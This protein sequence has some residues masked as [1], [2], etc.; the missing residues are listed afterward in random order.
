MI[1]YILWDID[2]TLLDFDYAEF[3]SL[4]ECFEKFNVG[5]LT[6]ERFAIYREINRKYWKVLER[7]EMD[8][9]EMLENRFIEFFTL[10]NIDTSIAFE[11]NEEYQKC[12]GKY[13]KFIKNAEETVK[14]FK[15][16]YKQ[17]AV[18]NGTLVAQ[19]K[20]LKKSGLYTLLD[21]SFISE[22]IGFDKPN[23]DFFDVVMEKIG[24][25][26]L[27]EYIIIGDSLTSDIQGGIN[28]GIK[29]CWF[30]PNCKENSENIKPDYE[31]KDLS[32]VKMILDNLI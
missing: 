14:E 18:T 22:E 29:T 28:I 24:S 2:K 31:I 21:D 6:D 26:N 23:K 20:K 27:D 16:K 13:V 1:K 4:K 11:F 25:H 10:Y 5:Q 15:D 17:Y 32:E 7:Q 30:N 9:K 3:Y 8:K 19:R 12:I